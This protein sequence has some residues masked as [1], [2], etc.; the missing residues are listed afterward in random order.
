MIHILYDGIIFQKDPH[1]GIARMFR[2]ILPRMCAMEPGLRIK[3]FI[4]GPLRGELPVHPQIIIQKAPAVKRTLRVQGGWRTL[5]YP[6]RRIASKVWNW[7]RSFWLGRGREVIWHSTYY[8][9]PEIWKGPQVVTVHDMIHERFPEYYNDPLDEVA[10]R[11]KQRCVE[12][13]NVIIC[14]SDVTRQDV[15]NWYGNI[16]GKLCVIPIAYNEAFHILQPEETDFP[17]VPEQSFILYVGGRSH[18]KNYKSLL[19]VYSQWE[20]RKDIRLVVVGAMWSAE[21]KQQL[22]HLGIDERVQLFHHLEDKSLCKLYNRALA[23][24][25]PSLYEGFGIPLLEA[26]ACGCPVIASHIPTTLEVAG[27]CPIYFEPSEPNTLLTALDQA[28]S[29]VKNSPRI[30]NGLDR[31]HLFS[32]DRT[33]RQTLDV[34]R[35]LPI[36]HNTF[37]G[38]PPTGIHA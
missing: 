37:P 26:M 4:D 18:Y 25:F 2:E 6:A 29:G 32:W 21:E 34:Y 11:Q 27:D 19:E 24:V 7:T 20:G 14:D 5:I 9:M 15:E 33:A 36:V 8:T 23:F 17:G 1:G 30:Q 22:F 12:H 28:R 35:E 13:A 10:R 16:T 3:I 38:K 31:V